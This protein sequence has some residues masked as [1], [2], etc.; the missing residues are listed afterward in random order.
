MTPRRRYRL[1]Q[2]RWGVVATVGA[3]VAGHSWRIG[4][5]TF[6]LATAVVAGL[7]AR[8]VYV[9]VDRRNL[10]RLPG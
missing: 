5:E 4:E 1:F 10:S 2:A 3:V 6:A 8:V 9:T 7:A